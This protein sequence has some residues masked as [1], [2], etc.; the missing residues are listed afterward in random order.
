MIMSVVPDSTRTQANGMLKGASQA[1]VATGANARGGILGVGMAG[2][3]GYAGK[4][5][6]QIFKD[7]KGQPPPK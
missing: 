7:M 2:T 1:P 3:R 4:P 6:G 5:S